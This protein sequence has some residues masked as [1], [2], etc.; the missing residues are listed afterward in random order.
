MFTVDSFKWSCLL[1]V[2]TMPYMGMYLILQ[3]ASRFVSRNCH[4][5]HIA[6]PERHGSNGAYILFSDK[7]GLQL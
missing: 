5:T 4:A 3:S 7:L 2:D 6:L 1:F